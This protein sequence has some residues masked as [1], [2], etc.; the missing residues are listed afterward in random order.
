MVMV[1]DGFIALLV[2]AGVLDVGTRP[3]LVLLF[4]E[5]EGLLVSRSP[6]T[7]LFFL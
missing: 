3:L 6:Q 1:F 7:F 2:T 5:M 4:P